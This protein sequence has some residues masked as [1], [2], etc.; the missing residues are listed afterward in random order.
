V[1]DLLV[2]VIG[3]ARAADVGDEAIA[4]LGGPS[5]DVRNAMARVL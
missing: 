3:P 4:A 1:P 5:P 2:E